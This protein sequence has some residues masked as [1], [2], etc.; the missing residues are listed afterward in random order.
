VLAGIDR[1]VGFGWWSIELAFV[2]AK[3]A[4]AGADNFTRKVSMN[5]T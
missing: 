4:S 5:F 1:G 2:V 3:L